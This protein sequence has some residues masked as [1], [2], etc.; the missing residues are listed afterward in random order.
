MPNPWELNWN[1]TPSSTESNSNLSADTLPPVT[2]PIP[3]FENP[4]DIL[5]KLS[6]ISP[7][8]EQIKATF[9]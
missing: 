4:W 1:G 8:S 2:T 3:D 9:F 7:H 6:S 5:P